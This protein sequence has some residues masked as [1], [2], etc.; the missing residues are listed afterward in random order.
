[1]NTWDVLRTHFKTAFTD[2]SEQE[3]ARD[4]LRKLRMTKGDIDE[5]IAKFQSLVKK[6]GSSS[7]DGGTLEM[8][9]RGLPQ[10]LATTC[11]TADAPNTFDEWV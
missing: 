4:E 8:F 2:Y 5:Y 11:I 9:S 6:T 3:C 1:M 10:V 7:D